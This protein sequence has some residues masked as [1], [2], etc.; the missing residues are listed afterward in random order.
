SDPSANLSLTATPKRL[1]RQ[2]PQLFPHLHQLLNV[3]RLRRPALN[4]LAA[5]PG[6][7]ICVLQ[8]GEAHFGKTVAQSGQLLGRERRIWHVRHFFA[9]SIAFPADGRNP[10]LNGKFPLTLL[11][12]PFRLQLLAYEQSCQTVPSLF[13]LTIGVVLSRLGGRGASGE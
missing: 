9:S 1:L 13:T 8:S 5:S 4:R 6:R 7:I 11:S 12:K 2:A 10:N 3:R